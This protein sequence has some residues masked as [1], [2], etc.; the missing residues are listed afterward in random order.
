MAEAERGLARNRRDRLAREELAVDEVDERGVDVECRIEIGDGSAPEDAPDERAVADDRPRVGRQPVDPR[1]DQRLDGVRDPHGHSLAPLGEHADRLLDEQR[2]A[3]GLL[4]EGAAD[5]VGQHRVRGEGV[6]EHL[7]LALG[8]RPEVDRDRPAPP[9]SPAR[10]RLEQL[11]AR[12]A[13]DEH[14][15]VVDPVRE[16]LD[17]VE[18]RIL[19]P[20]DVL[21]AEHERLRLGEAHRPLL[22]GPRDLL[23]APPARDGVEHTGRETEEIGD[24][25]ARA[26]LAELLEC[27]LGGVVG[28][29]PGCRLHHLRQRPVREAF[30]EGQ[31]PPGEHGRPLEAGEELAG[32]TALPDA[33]L[34]EDRDELR[35]AVADGARERVLEQLE[36][37]L[38]A[39]VRPDDVERTAR[40]ALRAHDP[41]H[42]EASGEA[43]ERPLA[44]RLRH[45]PAGEPARGRAHEDLARL[46]GLL[47]PC[48]DIERLAGREGRVALVDDDLT[49]LD[50]DADGELAVPR[51]DD[52]DR[53]T[54][55]ALGVVLV[56]GRHA[57]DG[58]HG[59]AGELLDRPAVRLDVRP[60]PVE[61]ARHTPPRDLRV[62]RGDERGRVHEVDEQR[63]RE[64]ALHA[65]KSRVGGR[66]EAGGLPNPA[67]V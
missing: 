43:L 55:R 27:L 32:E 45:D 33:G 9:S 63:R 38:A 57:E 67:T 42:L 3:L 44:E 39:D 41:P 20:V 64:L 61:E 15:R 24:R 65:S 34:P 62:V 60:D 49:R 14:R 50:P 12:K 4:Q 23:P 17:E 30:A 6:D 56:C 2:V 47:E 37:L 58:E 26:R 22:R 52:R 29:D 16:V 13:H 40:R 46:R 31:R 25:V 35:T 54:H 21:E 18:K 5:V 7:D 51:L 19:G 11:G 28:R 8:Q 48:R 66:R 59:V 36:L 53:G 10:P 1:R